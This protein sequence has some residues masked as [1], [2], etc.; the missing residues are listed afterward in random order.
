MQNNHEEVDLELHEI[1]REERELKTIL[2]FLW[3]LSFL[4][5]AAFL[6]IVVKTVQLFFI[7]ANDLVLVMITSAAFICSGFTVALY[8]LQ[9]RIDRIEM[10]GLTIQNEVLT[11]REIIGT[12]A[13][14]VQYR[15]RQ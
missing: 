11:N 9:R 5:S 6:C 8:R 10:H 12:I 15:L 13:S 3:P 4:S 7:D 1:V 2:F 14:E